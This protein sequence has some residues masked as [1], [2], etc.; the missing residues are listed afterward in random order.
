MINHGRVERKPRGAPKNKKLTEKFLERVS[1]VVGRD[2]TTSIRKHAQ[3]LK[4]NGPDGTQKAWETIAGEAA[5]ASTD[6]EAKNVAIGALQAVG[7]E[8]QEGSA[9]VGENFHGQE[10]FHGRP[11]LQLPERQSEC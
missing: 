10:A 5:S 3:K 11:V 6:G 4:V 8:A 1:N 9:V 7:V 2:P